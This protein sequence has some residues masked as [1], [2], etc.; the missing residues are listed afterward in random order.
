MDF[1]FCKIN[2]SFFETTNVIAKM[3]ELK[4]CQLTFFLR[5]VTGHNINRIYYQFETFQQS[6][7]HGPDC[8]PLTNQSHSHSEICHKSITRFRS[9][10]P[11][12]QQI[13]L[14]R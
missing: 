9:L 6:Q 1:H 10:R 3:F 8:A 11:Y 7:L 2:S 12:R 5:I 14:I 4:Y 13:Q